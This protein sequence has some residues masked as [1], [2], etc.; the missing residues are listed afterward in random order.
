MNFNF[1]SDEQSEEMNDIFGNSNNNN[2]K[3]EIDNVNSIFNTNNNNSNEI[4]Q[5]YENNIS[6]PFGASKIKKPPSNT[7]KSKSNLIKQIQSKKFNYF[8]TQSN[9]SQKVQIKNLIY[10]KK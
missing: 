9:D 5:P 10:Q 4:Q 8:E 6:N 3:E 1:F 7:N 2:N